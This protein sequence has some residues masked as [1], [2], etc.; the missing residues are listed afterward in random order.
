VKDVDDVDS[1]V[2]WMFVISGIVTEGW[3]ARVKETEGVSWA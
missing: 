1:V 3:A 2:D